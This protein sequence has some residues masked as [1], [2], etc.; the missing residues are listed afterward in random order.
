MAGLAS[1]V[2]SVYWYYRFPH[3]YGSYRGIFET[4]D[5][6]IAA[7]PNQS[8]VGYNN[9]DLAQE[10]EQDF[11]QYY[12]IIGTFDYPVLFWLKGLLFEHC[13]VFDFGG[14]VGNRFYAYEDYLNYPPH[15]KWIVCELP[16]ILKIGEKIAQ[17]E[18]RSNITFTDQFDQANGT[19]IL[20][21]SGSIQ[22]LG[23]EFSKQL[24]SLACKPRHL[25]LNR[26]PLCEGKQFVTLQNG[27][28]VFYPAFVMNK[29]EFIA[30]ICNLGYE[31][32][33]SW[34]D[35]SEPCA[36]PFHPEFK[37]LSFHGL[38]FKLLS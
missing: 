38:Y 3:A 9:A 32:G 24:G 18:K 1:L 22:Y 25:I 4:F 19:D 20:L 21:A 37:T 27:G 28:L 12:K 33:D 17:Q 35:R 36:V 29:A 11:Y 10:Y 13:T 16:E 15:L 34:Q 8:K 6:A 14:N 31:L 30:S 23:N 26:L 2:R 5:Q 7:V